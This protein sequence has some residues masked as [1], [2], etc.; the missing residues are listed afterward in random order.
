MLGLAE[1]DGVDHGSLVAGEEES[2]QVA[3]LGRVTR[4]RRSHQEHGDRT[5]EDGGAG[6]VASGLHGLL[7]GV[8]P[9]HD[10]LH[11]VQPPP[12]GEVEEGEKEEGK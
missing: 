1:Q 5:D 2:R 9:P 11:G 6:Q 8:A 12:D 7:A 10:F 3:Y 4:R